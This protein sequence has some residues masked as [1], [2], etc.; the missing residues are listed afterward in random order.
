MSTHTHTHTQEYHIHVR[1]QNQMRHHKRIFS[2]VTRAATLQSNPLIKLYCYFK[3]QILLHSK[4]T[5]FLYTKKS[6]NVF[7]RTIMVFGISGFRS[8][9][10]EASSLLGYYENIRL[11]LVTDIAGDSISPVFTGQVVLRNIREEPKPYE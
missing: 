5:T 11:Y 10:F 6:V 3:T 2:T 1:K 7:Y 8:C 9:V 4:H